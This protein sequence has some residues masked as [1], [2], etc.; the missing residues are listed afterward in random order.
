MRPIF[1]G[2]E[3]R[4]GLPSGTVTFLFTDIEGS[5]KL[6]EDAADAMRDSLARHDSLLRRAIEAHEGHVF[7]TGGD[8]LAAAFSRAVDAVEAAVEAQQRLAT[9]RWPAGAPIKVRMALHTGEAEERDGDYFGPTLNRA[10]RLMALGHGGQVLCTRVTADLLDG[11]MQM[12]DLGEHR[13]RDL[14]APQ[15]VFQVGQGSFPP[16]QSV[17]SVPSNLPTMHTELIGRSGEIAQLASALK[18]DRLLTLTGVGGV[19]KTRLALAIAAAIAPEFA[20]GCWLAELAPVADGDDVER[21]VCAALGAPAV[22]T[23]PGAGLRSYLES[24]CLVLVLDNCEH[25]LDACAALVEHVLSAATD[26]H[27]ITTSRE[28][29]GL[30]GEV[31][32]RVRSLDVPEATSD[33]DAVQEAGAVRLFVDR[34]V[35]ASEA[36]TLTSANVADV[37][38][39]CR[40]LDGIPLAIEL[41][42]ARVGSMSVHDI[43]RR[44]DERFRLLAGGRRAQE[45][46][47]TLQAAVSWSYDLLT[48]VERSVFQQLAVFPASFSLAAVE[49]IVVGDDFDGLDAVD[50]T[51]HLAERSLVQYDPATGRY[52]LLETLRQFGADRLSEAGGSDAVRD[53]YAAYYGALVREYAPGMFDHRYR[54][55]HDV[56]SPELDNVRATVDW[57]IRCERWHDLRELCHQGAVNFVA[58]YATS[59]GFEWY[60]TAV[61][62][63]AITDAQER[64]DALGEMSACATHVGLY[65]IADALARE[66]IELAEREGVEHCPWSWFSRS[67]FA[68]YTPNA[69]FDESLDLCR[70]MCDAA[71]AR[72]A[73]PGLLLLA[74]SNLIARLAVL[75]H[76]EEAESRAPDV[77]ERAAALDNAMVLAIVV[78][79][80]SSWY[81]FAAEEPDLQRALSLFERFDPAMEAPGA[82]LEA[83][84]A[85]MR[86]YAV[87]WRDPV[88][89]IPYAVRAVRMGDRTGAQ[90]VMVIA[91]DILSYILAVVGRT[92]EARHLVRAITDAYLS[93]GPGYDRYRRQ[94]D[95]ILAAS[96]PTAAGAKLTRQQLL[97]LLSSLETT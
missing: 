71:V 40:K 17:D 38:E 42:A 4:E 18:T 27:I 52:R 23:T 33:F 83:W 21:A 82:L 20:D 7:S 96:E 63:D 5:T 36:F 24:R 76:H 39:I 48:P 55:A 34:A 13:L 41:A 54:E 16:L 65:D 58:S 70:R 2:R 10:A 28:P 26:V 30:D 47:R 37:L 80:L 87:S 3:V 68:M 29:L 79:T 15:R 32:R 11:A 50:A 97:A 86:C 95:A 12:I 92:A 31:V 43:T 59:E 90:A 78:T 67:Q 69:G 93:I 22:A 56:L 66:S 45:R 8:G 77:I 9:E 44:L 51:V 84:L 75:G 19:G 64:V 14:L 73:A 57:F 94:R 62:S 89:A 6:W 72:A 61:T 60:Q 53:R 91:L 46:H 88:E 74:E 25:V 1:Y 85:V 49:H 35:A 81:L